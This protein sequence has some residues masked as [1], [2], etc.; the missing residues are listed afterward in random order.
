MNALARSLVA[1]AVDATLQ[2][3][4]VASG[5][6]HALLSPSSAYAWS[7]CPVFVALS[8]DKPDSSNAYSIEGTTAHDLGAMALVQGAACADYTGR[9]SKDTG[10]AFTSDMARDTQIYVDNIRTLVQGAALVLIEQ[11]V[12]IDHMTLEQGATGKADC[13]AVM[14]YLEPATGIH[15]GRY[16]IDVHDLKFGHQIVSPVKNKQELMYASAAIRRVLEQY[17]QLTGKIVGVRCFIHQPRVQHDP[18]EWA[19]SFEDLQAFERDIRASA[20]HAWQVLKFEKPSAYLHHAKPSEDTCHYCK[21]KLECEAY[22]RFHAQTVWGSDVNMAEVW[23]RD[24]PPPVEEVKAANALNNDVKLDWWYLRLGALRAFASYIEE[25]LFE[26]AKAGNPTPGTKLV[27]GKMGNR[28]WADE[29]AALRL[30][31][32]YHA[33]DEQIYAPDKIVSPAEAEKTFK[34]NAVELWVKLDGVITQA[35]GGPSLTT[36]DD[37]RPEWKPVKA[38]ETDFKDLTKT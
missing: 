14:P 25:V 15:G 9:V 11:P 1:Q 7:V 6:D 32:D 30:M 28:Q 5:G 8:K 22:E 2:M 36:R 4:G 17:P 10:K 35:P 29:L 34:K 23:A 12:P 20:Y 19:C 38:D 33:T 3:Q 27:H 13:I 16:F 24:V 18:Q 37:P 21:G 26:R 31:R